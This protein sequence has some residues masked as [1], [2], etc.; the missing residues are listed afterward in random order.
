MS[1]E[2]GVQVTLEELKGL[3]TNHH[4]LAANGWRR[5]GNDSFAAQL[6]IERPNSPTGL[7]IK[8]RPFGNCTIINC[9]FQKGLYR[10]VFAVTQK[11]LTSAI[12]RLEKSNQIIEGRKP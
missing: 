2:G 1:K 9:A 8:V 3:L 10:T 7:K 5:S 12:N 11:Q 4:I 6:V